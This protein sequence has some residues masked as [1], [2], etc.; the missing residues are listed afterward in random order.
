VQRAIGAQL[1]A[2]GSRPVHFAFVK[3][4]LTSV[5]VW[6]YVATYRAQANRLAATRHTAIR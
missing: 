6:D 1:A 3:A 4:A 2:L 5:G